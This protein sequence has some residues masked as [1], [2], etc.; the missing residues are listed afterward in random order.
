MPVK[1]WE[2]PGNTVCNYSLQIASCAWESHTYTLTNTRTHSQTH[3]HT[4]ARGTYTRGTHRHHS[5]CLV[6]RN[7]SKKIKN[8]NDYHSL[9]FNTKTHCINSYFCFVYQLLILLRVY[10]FEQTNEPHRRK[11]QSELFDSTS[12]STC[13]GTATSSS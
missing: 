5:R 8:H 4:H 1:T 3:T 6:Q 12:T 11:T 9:K 13:C 7:L 10:A 2:S